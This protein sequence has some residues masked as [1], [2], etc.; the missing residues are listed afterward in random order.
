MNFRVQKYRGSDVLTWWKGRS[1]RRI[2]R[3]ERAR[4]WITPTSSSPSQELATASRA[5]LHEFADHLRG[6][7]LIAVYS[8]TTAD[9]SGVGGPVDGTRRRRDRAGGRRS[10]S[11]R[12]PFGS[13]SLDHVGLNESLPRAIPTDPGLRLLPP[14]LNQRRHKT[15][16]S[17]SPRATPRPSTRSTG[18]TGQVIWRLGGKKS[19]F[20]MGPGATFSSQHDARGPRRRNDDDLLQRRVRLGRGRRRRPRARSGSHST[21][22]AMTANLVRVHPDHKRHALYP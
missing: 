20:K 6:T 2:R 17:L 13:H 9:L 22:G 3:R 19:D 5:H 15:A 21:R 4:S 11:G 12:V 8:E 14:Q 10:G 16:T 7:A 1:K 18:S